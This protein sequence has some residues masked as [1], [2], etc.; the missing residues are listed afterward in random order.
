MSNNINIPGKILAQSITFEKSLD[1]KLQTLKNLYDGVKVLTP[2]KSRQMYDKLSNAIE[3]KVNEINGLK[4]DF[5]NAVISINNSINKTSEFYE[6]LEKMQILL[7]KGK[8]GT[9]EGI[10]RENI[11]TGK[12]PA[13]N[14][15]EEEKEILNQD[16]DELKEVNKVNVGGFTKKRKGTKRKAKKS[17]TTKTHRFHKIR[18]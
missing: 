16:Y 11:K 15:Y 10:T 14:L 2:A 5:T 6:I 3:D 13:E 18:K 4:N 12:F 17:K 1:D 9:L 8:V 7:N